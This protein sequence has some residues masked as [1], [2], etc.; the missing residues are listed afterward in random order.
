MQSNREQQQAVGSP[1]T[2]ASPL[3][4]APVGEASKPPGAVVVGLT[5]HDTSYEIYPRTY[6]Y[7]FVFDYARSC[8]VQRVSIY[9][10][11]H[12]EAVGST[13]QLLMPCVRGVLGLNHSTRVNSKLVL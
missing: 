1:A 4:E 8:A 12:P 7:T 3:A 11:M 5:P 6:V 9:I 13:L 10:S 2:G